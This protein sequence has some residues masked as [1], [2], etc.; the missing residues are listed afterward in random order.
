MGVKPLYYYYSHPYFTF[1]SRPRA[2]FPLESTI[3]KKI[4][5]QALRYYLEIG[6]IPA[7]YSIYNSISKLPPAHYLILN[8]I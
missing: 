7:P 8:R 6:Y 1:A 2:I 4:D 3:S 5:E